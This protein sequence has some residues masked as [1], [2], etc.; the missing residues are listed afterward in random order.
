MKSSRKKKITIYDVAKHAGV[1][2]GTASRAL[3]DIG[4]VKK[5]THEKIMK[6]ANVLEYIPNT[7]GK[8]LKTTKTGLICLAIPDTSN[9]IYFKMIESVLETAKENSYSMLL[10]FTH[11]LEKEELK[12]LR[13]LQANTVDALIL[14]HF[15]Y[16]NKLK[17]ALESCSQP[18]VL[19]GMC[20]NLWADEPDNNFDTI[21]IDVYQGIYNCVTYL[22]EKGH[23]DII[24]FAGKRGITVY[25]Q[26]FDAYRQALHDNNIRYVEKNIF[27][28]SYDEATGRIAAEHFLKT[29]NIPSAVCASNDLQAIGYY[30]TMAAA[31]VDVKAH[32][33]MVSVD[34]L[35]TMELLN[36]S[37]LNI[38]EADVG[39]K[40]AELIFQRIHTKGKSDEF[41]P[42]S[43]LFMPDLIVRDN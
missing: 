21:S 33:D 31:G 43:I 26:R 24:Y 11:G 17:V 15:S 6:S 10:Y 23:K 39:R 16:S 1:A 4:Y 35:E 27:W 41:F 28:H 34:N 22:I 13:I 36:I 18:I 14:I 12:A 32:T 3:N 19:C 9:P 20:N 40:A 38:H 5:E 29:G 42:Q 37:S 2:P 30:R 8:A 7:A 25:K